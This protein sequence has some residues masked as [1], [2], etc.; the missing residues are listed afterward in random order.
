MKKLL[1]LCLAAGT[2]AGCATQ[3]FTITPDS[4][5]EFPD[6]EVSQ[7]FFVGGIAQRKHIDAAKL[8]GGTHKI[9]R[10]ETIE[11]PVDIVLGTLTFGIYTPKTARVYCVKDHQQPF[12]KLTPHQ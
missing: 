10:I 2:L 7:P 8:C 5:P 9:A 4:S 1:A 12:A 3:T 11:S 6:R